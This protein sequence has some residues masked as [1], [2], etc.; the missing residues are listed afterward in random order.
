MIFI[1][2]WIYQDV[3]E[4]YVPIQIDLDTFKMIILGDT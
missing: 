3:T 2:G 1:S 4:S